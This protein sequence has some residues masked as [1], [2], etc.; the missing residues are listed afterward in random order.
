VFI[1]EIRLKNFLSFKDA[2]VK[3]GQL[4]AIMGVNGSGKSNFLDA[5]KLIRHAP[6]R[7]D[8]LF[9]KSGV[10]EWIWNG[11]KSKVATIE[12]VLG[13]PIDSGKIKYS[14]S[15]ASEQQRLKLVG[16]SIIDEANDNPCIYYD[17]NQGNPILSYRTE[18]GK[19]K[20]RRIPE[21]E[22]DLS[23]SILAQ[24]RDAAV[25]P[26]ITA[27]SKKLASIKI[28]SEWSFGA[29]SPLRRPQSIDS[30][31]DYLE[32]DFSNLCLILN[33]IKQTTKPLGLLLEALRNLDEK[34]VDY[35]TLI[36]GGTVQLFIIEKEFAT[37]AVRLPDGT[38][39]F[40][41]L[42]AMLCHPNPPPLI[43]IDEP[44]FGI[45]RDLITTLAKLIENASERCQVIITT[46]SDILVDCMSDNENALLSTESTP[47]SGSV[48]EHWNADRV[49]AYLARFKLGGALRAK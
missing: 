32:T 48:I 10:Q 16:E 30:P 5:I 4:N 46:H 44:E 14:L 28:Y 27:I 17:F 42:L 24:K 21:G 25:Y 37:P 18:S 38:L 49:N 20:M 19:L 6:D 36:D 39:R 23:K 35:N 47:S 2:S 22:M 13:N 29:S 1:H 43:C 9:R 41:C 34:L 8:S 15:F 26:E 33:K 11:S 7:F 31:N 40:I 12:A 3:L 45:H